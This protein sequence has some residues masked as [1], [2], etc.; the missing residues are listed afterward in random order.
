[1]PA[2]T[3]PDSPQRRVIIAQVQTSL[4]AAAPQSMSTEKAWQYLVEN[5]PI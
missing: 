1:M 4:N 5:N 3:A 2:E